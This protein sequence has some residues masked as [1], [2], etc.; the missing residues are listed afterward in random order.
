MKYTTLSLA[1]AAT[2]LLVLSGC[3]TK[4]TP[5]SSEVPVAETTSTHDG[6]NAMEHTHE[7]YDVPE[8]VPVPTVELNVNEDEKGGWNVQIITTNFTFAP[9][10]VN[11]DNVD[12]EGHAHIY[13]DGEKVTRVYSEW[14]YLG[15]LGEGEYEISVDLNTNQH[16]VYA[17]D[18][19]P[20]EA[21]VY[22]ETG[23]GSHTHTEEHAH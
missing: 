22:V 14:Y 8:G 11:Q 16:D 10:R 2:G 7:P 5:S 3:T 20:I 4:T 21:S 18:G 15:D 6:H 19:E 13:V 12:G 1:V 23:E 9:E 17:V